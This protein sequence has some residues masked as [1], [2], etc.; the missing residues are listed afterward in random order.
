MTGYILRRLAFLPP[1][2]L[3]ISAVVFFSMRLIPIDPA[4]LVVGPYASAEQRVLATHEVGLDRPIPVQFAIYLDRIAHGDFGRSLKSGKKITE[5]IHDTVPNTLLLGG[6]SLGLAYLIAIPLGVIAA[7][8]QNS[9]V[10][11]SAMGFALLGI[12]LPNFWLG[13]LLVLLFAVNLRW[14]PATGS[15]TA[16]HLILPAITLG[17]QYTAIVARMTRSS[18]LE[19]LRQDFVRT[20]HAK[21]L[22]PRR[23]I[24]LHVLKNAVIPVI[25]LLGLHVGSIVGGSVIVETIF[26]W[27]G[28]GAML[29]NAITQRDYPVVQASLTLLG[30]AVLA[31]NLLA[32]MLYSFTDRRIRYQ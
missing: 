5:L 19:V 21:G 16:A 22:R 2:A 1:M 17:L 11:Q 8:R 25:S 20:L 31:A 28:M 24:S 7:V 27:P 32:D 13:L 15:G 29:V 18:V 9:W 6:L 14:L 26:A 30:I 3:I 10:D 23:I 4:E 12:S